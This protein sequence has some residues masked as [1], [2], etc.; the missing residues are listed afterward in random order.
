M[1]VRARWLCG[2]QLDGEY[3]VFG[4]R[5][6]CNGTAVRAYDLLGDGKPQSSA[7]AIGRTRR[8]QAIELLKDHLELSRRDANAVRKALWELQR[9]PQLFLKSRQEYP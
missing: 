1:F 6:T 5:F 7:A 3:R 4:R 8:I 9:F 2:G